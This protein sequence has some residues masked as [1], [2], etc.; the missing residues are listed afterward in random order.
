MENSN[1]P[2]QLKPAREPMPKTKEGKMAL[3][4][5]IIAIAWGVLLIPAGRIFRGILHLRMSSIPMVVVEIAL[6]IVAL[7]LSI[8]AIFKVKDKSMWNL[9]V[10][11]ILCVVGGFWV[12]FA[13]GEMLFPH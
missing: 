9:V 2:E 12:L 11:V 13:G 3:T 6:F 1:S 10:F 8:R 7:Y 5:G 4:F